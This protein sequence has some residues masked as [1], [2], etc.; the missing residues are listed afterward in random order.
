[1]VETMTM[2][3]VRTTSPAD[4]RTQVD[5]DTCLFELPWCGKINLRGELNN[6]QFV[7]NVEST[8]GMML[9]VVAHTC[10]KK[11][12]T[13]LYWLGPNEWLLHCPLAETD[14]TLANLK[15]ALLGSHSAI[16]EVTDY[17]TVLRLDG[18]D[19][20]TLLAKA[21]PMDLHPDI[22]M[23]G[24]CCQTRFGHASILLHKISNTPTYDIQ[25]RWS[26]TEYVWD[27]LVSGMHT[28]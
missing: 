8:L 20:S 12:N 3:E 9:P 13:T 2:P 10:T 18:T 26:F 7:N 23:T 19:S 27:Y 5:G 6:P 17:Y 24:S 21:C 28:L 15:V 22:F 1:M 14:S 25:V 16:V 4:N 11:D